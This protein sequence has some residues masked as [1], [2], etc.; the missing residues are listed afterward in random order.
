MNSMTFKK[1]QSYKSSYQ[2][3]N[4]CLPV[5]KI[6]LVLSFFPTRF[7]SQGLLNKDPTVW[8]DVARPAN[9]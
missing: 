4:I 7:A 9:T 6:I 5:L 1:W 8:L 3:K 2:M